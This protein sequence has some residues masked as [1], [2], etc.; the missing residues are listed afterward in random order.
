MSIIND[1]VPYANKKVFAI[2]TNEPSG[3]RTGSSSMASTAGDTRI[4]KQGC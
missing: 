4:R 2:C 3:F 1:L